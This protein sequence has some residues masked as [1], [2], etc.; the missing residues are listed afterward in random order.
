M[1]TTSSTSR[2]EPGPAVLK[3]VFRI[4]LL[5]LLCVIG[6]AATL[7]N[8]IRFDRI[9]RDDG[10]SQ[11]TGLSIFQDSRGFIW[12]GTEEGLN[13]YDGY[14]FTVY[15]H[16]PKDPSSLPDN[17]IWAIDEDE[18]GDLWIGTG[19]GGIVRWDFRTDRFH[20]VPLKSDEDSPDRGANV[21]TLHISRN[22]VVWVG[23][24]NR[25][26][27]LARIDI[28]S[29]A[30]TRYFHDP[31]DPASLSSD[32]VYAIVEDRGGNLW[33]GTDNGLNRLDP[34]TGICVRYFNDPGKDDSLSD[35][36]VR[37]LFEDNNHIWVGTHGGGLNRLDP[38]NGRFSRFT[39]DPD[40]PSS[41][42]HNRVRTILK[43]SA[44]RIW[45]GTSNGLNLFQPQS[46]TF[47][48]YLNDPKNLMSLS[49]N[50]IFTIFEDRGGVLWI[51]T[52]TGG[53]NKWNPA[54]WSFG[55]VGAESSGAMGVGVKNVSSFAEDA[56]GRIWIGSSDDGLI[57]LNRITGE[58]TR[59]RYDPQ[60]TNSLGSDRVM[61][62]QRDRSGMLWIGTLDRGLSRY[63]PTDGTFSIFCNDPAQPTSL[64]ANG[65]MCLFEDSSGVLWIG[66]FG[67]GLNRF[68]R[69]S[70]SFTRYTHDPSDPSSLSFDR[71]TCMTEDRSGNLWIGTDGGGLNLF[72]R[73][74]EKFTAF[75]H[76]PNDPTSLGSDTV[77]SLH[78]DASA[79]LWVGTRGRGLFKLESFD[80]S[81][82]AFRSYT[83]NDGLPDGVIYGIQSDAGGQLWLSTVNGLACLNP[84]TGEIN[85]Y[86]VSHGLQDN[87]FN[88]GASFRDSQGK[89]YFGGLKGY[90]AF[91]PEDLQQNQHMPP[92]VLTSYLKSNMPVALDCSVSMLE[93]VELDYEDDMV[94]LE[95]AALD[96]S[97][98]ED[99]R[100][101]CKLEGFDRDW[102]DLGPIRRQ[103]YTNLDPGDYT[104]GVRGANND[105]VWNET[106]IAL[107]MVVQPPPWQTWWAYSIY[108]LILLAVIYA[109]VLAQKK[110]LALKE[111]YSRTL[112]VQVKER[113]EEL[114]ERNQELEVL[115]EKFLDASL[116]DPLTGLR[117]RRYFF[118]HIEQEIGAVRRRFDQAARTGT[119][120]DDSE[121]LF[122]MI[123]IDLF[124][125]VNDTYGHA[126]GDRVILAF[127]D[128]MRETCRGSDIV[129][130]WGGDEFLL[131]GRGSDLRKA[132]KLAERLRHRIMEYAVVLENGKTVHATCSIGFACFPFIRSQPDLH[133]WDNVLHLADTALYVAKKTG[134][135]AWVGFLGEEST[136]DDESVRTGDVPY[137]R[138]PENGIQG[139]CTSIPDHIPLLWPD[140]TEERIIDE[141]NKIS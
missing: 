18:N 9:S 8:T 85:S 48:H 53:I 80:D 99:N 50:N 95:F 81:N 45:V 104:F 89:L 141:I 87:E 103:T 73:E 135:N 15:K 77:F 115:N 23:L 68:D 139:V 128:V 137:N 120:V 43:D 111:E 119:K 140:S 34:S 92:V 24:R 22:N 138:F 62:L 106:G 130:R 133:S 19:N 67:G 5:L 37:S 74:T 129:I 38:L 14:D 56:H 93:S 44:G 49:D 78:V 122:M 66:T 107:G 109:F 69:A 96:Y 98:P 40:D 132:H 41:L 72:N 4:S 31:S 11:S 84:R 86:F 136:L 27:G 127:R 16:D 113:T 79:N 60:N 83:E 126:A 30:I 90:N 25:D 3:A 57:G 105:G 102:I 10:L 55:H 125:Q 82:A 32:D 2:Q 108:T 28:T 121:L 101:T 131:L 112:E 75:S 47:T 33:V 21:R 51:G 59:Q 116:T 54:T 1:L 71:V 118:E 12:I 134:R 88:F 29:G 35:D 46:G 63:D 58:V 91:R 76:D 114:A 6:T 123:D 97:A 61:A 94:T 52:R 17:T 39:N 70:D 13:R 124:K 42:T 110:K 20:Q 64:G 65:I 26:K 36:K 117:N 7:G 100:Y